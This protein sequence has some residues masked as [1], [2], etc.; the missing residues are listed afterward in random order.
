MIRLVVRIDDAAMAANVG[1]AVHTTYRTFD[2]EHDEIE[3][4]LR[5]SGEKPNQFSYATVVGAALTAKEGSDN[6]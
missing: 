2:I 5:T 1:G 6:G 3:R 4:L